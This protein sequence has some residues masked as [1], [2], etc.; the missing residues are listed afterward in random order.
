ML[1]GAE[2]IRRHA[3][4]ILRRWCEEASRA[5]CA[6]G[7]DQSELED[8]MPFYVAAL[9]EGLD[10]TSS[11]AKR[12]RHLESHLAARIRHGFTVDEV[13][14]EIVLLG[15]SVQRTAE[16]REVEE[17]PDRGDMERLWAQLGADAAAVADM[18]QRHMVED[19]QIEKRYMRLLRSI[20]S[21]ALH[22]NGV[23]R[24][25]R[26][27]EALGLIMEAVGA[28]TAGLLLYRPKTR[29]LVSA[30]S[31]GV[32]AMQDWGSSLD[33]S[34]FAGHVAA[35]PEVIAVDDVATTP[36]EI[37]EELRT[38][39]VRSLMGVRLPTYHTLTGILYV[40]H[41]ERRPFT[42]REM[43]RLEALG[44]QLTIHIEN[45]ALLA[46]LESK[47]GALVSERELRERFVSV[48]AHD[49]RGPLNAAK[50]AVSSLMA[51]LQPEAPEVSDERRRDLA[52]RIDR[53]IDRVDRM[54]RDLL[55]ANRIHAG[56]SVPLHLTECDLV[57]I[58]REAVDEL[59][60]THR[61]CFVLT[62]DEHVVG[63]W[64]RDEL[65]RAIWNLAV[66]AAKYGESGR[67]ITI[68]VGT[69]RGH[70]RVSVHNE[71]VPIPVEEQQGLFRPFARAA[72]TNG[73]GPRGWGLGL[74]LVRGVAE[75]HGGRVQVESDAAT[76]TTFT[77]DLPMDARPH[78]RGLEPAA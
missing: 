28:D 22:E 44:E 29:D 61:D 59:A 24:E 58:A 7:L 53:N 69:D 3:D 41:C 13:V 51:G 32:S 26:L 36:L 4:G 35:S 5:P 23:P 76:G 30:A 19:A 37:P 65:R 56:G 40:G 42:P 70:A 78:Q 33:P 48:L 74:T 54:V 66:N 72:S 34:S 15:L 68:H 49:L 11:S 55:D 60:E 50:L 1:S 8:S 57:E 43:R 46:E 21:A 12:R 18:F 16:A 10:E 14:R 64:G 17:R 27:E 25:S 77:L 63:M 9:A 31:A 2:F 75:A 67:P 47:I 52:E 39:G 20:G 6:R 71:G 38:A 45:A 62:G 73:H